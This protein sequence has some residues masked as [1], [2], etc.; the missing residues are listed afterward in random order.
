MATI[1][2]AEQVK[3]ICSMQS[4]FE[5]AG[6]KVN[7]RI[8]LDFDNTNTGGNYSTIRICDNGAVSIVSCDFDS[9]RKGDYSKK[10]FEE[11]ES[12]AVMEQAYAKSYGVKSLLQ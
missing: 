8:H 12:I 5:G 9:W 1:L 2:T 10:K 6:G 4:Q 11:F 3:A 7:M